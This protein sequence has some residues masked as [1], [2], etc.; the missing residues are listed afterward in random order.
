ME[1][2]TENE[3][4]ILNHWSMFG[5][6]GYPVNKRGNSWFVDGMRGCGSCP[7][8]FKTKREATE[9]WEKYID[10]LIDRNAIR[11]N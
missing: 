4:F 11:F 9:Q 2:L 1:T 5:S 3:D 6:D 7:A 10:V 8:S